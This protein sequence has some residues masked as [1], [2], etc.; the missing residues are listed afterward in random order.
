LVGAVLTGI[1]SLVLARDPS[2]QVRNYEITLEF[3]EREEQEN[4]RDKEESER[5][6]AHRCE[7]GWMGAES[8]DAGPF[9]ESRVRTGVKAGGPG[10]VVQH[11]VRVGRPIR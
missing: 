1:A 7:G 2:R 9:A 6:R 3:N 8:R 10:I 4:D 5:S 11:G